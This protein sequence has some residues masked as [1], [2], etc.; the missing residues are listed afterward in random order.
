M[1]CIPIRELKDTSNISQLC[2]AS[3]EPITITKNGYDDMV[4]M[5][6]EVYNRIRLYSIYEEL[7]KAEKDIADG[8]VRDAFSSINSIRSKYGL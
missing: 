4:I 7:M 2:H 6:T 8:N 1:Q 5:S 3:A